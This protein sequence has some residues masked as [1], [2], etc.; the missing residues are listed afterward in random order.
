MAKAIFASVRVVVLSE[1]ELLKVNMMI[2]WNIHVWFVSLVH[3]VSI[4]MMVMWMG[5]SM[6]VL[7]WVLHFTVNMCDGVV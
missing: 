1:W 2:S 7:N 5:Q 3:N 6:M 4:T